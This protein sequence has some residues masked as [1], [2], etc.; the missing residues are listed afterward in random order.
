VEEQTRRIPE[1]EKQTAEVSKKLDIASARLVD[2][3]K[4]K[5]ELTTTVQKDQ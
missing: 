2:L 3:Q 4:E 1:L 5:A